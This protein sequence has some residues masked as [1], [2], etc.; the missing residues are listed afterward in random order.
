MLEDRP[1]FGLYVAHALATFCERGWEFAIGLFILE[2]FPDTL[3]PVA[4]YGVFE[5][6]VKMLGGGHAGAYVDRTP[7]LEAVKK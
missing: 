7:R 4:A 6:L 2:I 5:G 1:F 3:L